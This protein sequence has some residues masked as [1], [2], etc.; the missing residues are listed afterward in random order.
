MQGAVGTGGTGNVLSPTQL[1][2][3]LIRLYCSKPKLSVFLVGPHGVGKSTVV[4]DTAKYL[5][6]NPCPDSTKNLGITKKE[7]VEINKIRSRTAKTGTNKVITYEDVYLHPDNYFL[8]YDLRL[9]E[10]E[11]QDLMGLPRITSLNIDK[12]Y[13]SVTT[14]APPSWAM[15]LSILALTVSYS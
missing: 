11:P 9:T 14:Y 2:R 10:L 12:E 6:D 13:Y 3:V 15:L 4:R 5:A 8:F 7:F 1:R